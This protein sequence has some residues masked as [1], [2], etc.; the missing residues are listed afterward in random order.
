QVDPSLY[1]GAVLLRQ[2]QPK[3]ALRFLTEA[4]RIDGNCPLVGLQLGSAMVAAGN[5]P[6]MAVKALQKALGSRGLLLYKLQ[7]DKLW[8]DSFTE[9]KSFV[10]GLARLF[11]FNCP[12]WGRDVTALM[13]QGNLALGQALYR[14][15]NYQEAADL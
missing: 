5:D 15:G 1:L 7:P 6:A 13:R 2:D 8:S 12:L 10:R 9:G 11:P 3:E 14:Q 4:Y